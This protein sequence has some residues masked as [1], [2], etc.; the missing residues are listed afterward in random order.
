MLAFGH[1]LFGIDDQILDHLTHL[2][3]ID[4]DIPQVIIDLEFTLHLRAAEDKVCRLLNNLCNGS[5]LFYRCTT[6]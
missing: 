6:L 2:S 4:I 3:G 5:G 1:S